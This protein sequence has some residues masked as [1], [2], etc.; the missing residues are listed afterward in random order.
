MTTEAIHRDCLRLQDFW[1]IEKEG[2]AGRALWLCP[3]DEDFPE[4]FPDVMEH[5]YVVARPALSHRAATR[6]PGS[7]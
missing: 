5:E 6:A 7:T 4:D 1:R 2:M 3:A